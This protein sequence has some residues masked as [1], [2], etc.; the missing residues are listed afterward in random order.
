MEELISKECF[1]IVTDL[2]KAKETFLNNCVVPDNE[3]YNLLFDY[4]FNSL[5]VHSLNFMVQE[6]PVALYDGQTLLTVTRTFDGIIEQD[7][8]PIELAEKL[9]TEFNEEILRLKEQGNTIVSLYKLQLVP[10]FPQILSSI[11]GEEAAKLFNS[12][13]MVS[14]DY[15]LDAKVRYSYI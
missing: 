7:F 2:V 12:A 11:V 4:F 6:S 9:A 8:N 10:T 1:G 5:D 3:K 14:G 15:D 13:K